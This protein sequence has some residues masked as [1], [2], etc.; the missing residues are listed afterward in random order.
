MSDVKGWLVPSGGVRHHY[1]NTLTGLSLC[2]QWVYRGG[3]NGLETW[4]H[5]GEIEDEKDDTG[6]CL[7]CSDVLEPEARDYFQIVASC[8][9]ALFYHRD[10]GSDYP[11]INELIARVCDKIEGER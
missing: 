2:G 8:L 1:F 6:E 7:S 4:R 10:R 5:L 9:D 11:K 3:I